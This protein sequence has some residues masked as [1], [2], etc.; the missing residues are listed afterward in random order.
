M[1]ALSATVCKLLESYRKEEGQRKE[2]KKQQQHNHYNDFPFK[3]PLVFPHRE[4]KRRLSGLDLF[5][6]T[7]CHFIA[8]YS[9]D[10]IHSDTIITLPI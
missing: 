2:C 7:C 5:P 9:F 6:P 8:V 4:K 1:F 3:I 10:S